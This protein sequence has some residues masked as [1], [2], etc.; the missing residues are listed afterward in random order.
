MRNG[1]QALSGLSRTFLFLCHTVM[2]EGMVITSLGVVGVG[3]LPASSSQKNA[4]KDSDWPV[5]GHMPSLP[6]AGDCDG[7]GEKLLPEAK[8]VITRRMTK[9]VLG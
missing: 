2:A 5:L 4:R 3:N 7:A 1:Q 8:S 9:G 6:V